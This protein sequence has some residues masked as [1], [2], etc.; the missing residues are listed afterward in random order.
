MRDMIRVM[1]E[2]PGD[3]TYDSV[4]NLLIDQETAAQ[5]SSYKFEELKRIDQDL[6]FVGTDISYALLPAAL[7]HLDEDNVFYIPDATADLVEQY[8]LRPWS[9]FF[10][11]TDAVAR[12]WR[13]TMYD[14]AGTL[15]RSIQ[16]LPASDIDYT[17]GR[18]R[19]NYWKSHTW[20]DTT[21]YPIIRLESVIQDKVAARIASLQSKGLTAKLQGSA[22]QNLIASR[23]AS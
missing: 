7:Q 14:D 10:T 9:K 22:R 8:I 3:N 21:E 17:N 19:I 23:G 11:Q 20:D 6:S 16:I 1:A 5:S 18:V 2:I 12:L 13:R 4:I 15:K